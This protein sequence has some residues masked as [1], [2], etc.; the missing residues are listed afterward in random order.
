MDGGAG[1]AG[2]GLRG[3]VLPGAS[4]DRRSA[5]P[6]Y[7]QLGALL[8]RAIASG[9]YRAGDRLP[10]ETELC[11]RFDLARSTVRETLRALQERGL[12]ELVPRRGAFV[13]DPDPPGWGLQVTAGFFE[14]EVEA[15]GRTVETEVLSA[16]SCRLSETAARA[17][18]RPVGSPG[19]ALRR[20]RRLDGAVALLSENV[21]V[22]E[23]AEIVLSP[24]VL[25]PRGSLNRALAA[26]G[27]RIHRARRSLEAVPAPAAVAG[28]LAV[29]EG[30]PLL[31]VTSVSWG[32]DGRPFDHYTAHVRTDVVKVTV[33]AEA[34]RDGEPAG[35]GGGL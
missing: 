6:F 21:L 23:L 3:V 7:R 27:W 2:E 12:V 19:V 30:A 25:A 11:R 15:N 16:G 35:R 29:A 31:L 13:R 4:I 17:L 5:D 22:P 8:E 26:A 28:L 10:G 24:A 9:D 1:E 14:G 20:L 32:R 18:Q 34:V 33:E